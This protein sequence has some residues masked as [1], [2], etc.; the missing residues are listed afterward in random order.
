MNKNSYLYYRIVYLATLTF[1]V[2]SKAW[3]AEVVTYFYPF[4]NRM[5]ERILFGEDYF[6]KFNP[7]DFLQTYYNATN[8]IS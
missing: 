4:L 6:D 7:Q 1:L 8:L 2:K 5:E 3:L